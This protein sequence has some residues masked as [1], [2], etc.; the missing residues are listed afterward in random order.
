VSTGR[1][2]NR[3]CVSMPGAPHEFLV[4][5]SLGLVAIPTLLRSAGYTVR[6]IDDVYEPRPVPDVE[7]IRDADANAWVVATKDDRIRRRPAEREALAS[8][9]LRVFCLTSGNLRSSEQVERFRANLA[10]MAAVIDQLGPWIRGVYVDRV[11]LLKIFPAK[12]GARPSSR[13]AAVVGWAT[14]RLPDHL[15]LRPRMTARTVALAMMASS[16]SASM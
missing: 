8:S 14:T 11:E 16:S 4:D 12:G 9:T 1:P 10:A 3:S 15:Q 13:G 2:S 7:W 5:R 6:T